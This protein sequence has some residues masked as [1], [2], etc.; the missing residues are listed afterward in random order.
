M[1][2]Q[3]SDRA[4][5]LVWIDSEEAIVVRW[6]DRA[7]L[8]R[9]RSDVPGRHRTPDAAPVDPAIRR[10]GGAADAH[11]RARRA[12]MRQFLGEVAG[13]VPEADDVTVVGPGLLRT[14]LE[15][16]LRADDR[17]HGRRRKVHSA[18]SGRLTDQELVAHV[19]L[20]AGDAAPRV[21]V[22]G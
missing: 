5:T 7:T 14:H 17:H 9:I 22:A 18:A 8:E 16:A 3:A 21:G 1:Q 6:T 20:L 10:D 12:S 11:E 13:R 4:T 19:R 2:T 15:Q